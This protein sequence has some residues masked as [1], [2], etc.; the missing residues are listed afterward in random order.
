MRIDAGFRLALYVMLVLACLCLSYAEQDFMP[1]IWFIG[2]PAVGLLAVAYWIEGRWYLSGWAANVL[3]F[4]IAIASSSRLSDPSSC[5]TTGCSRGS[6][7]CKLSWPL[8]SGPARSW[9][10]Y[11]APT[12]WAPC[13][14]F[15]YSNCVAWSC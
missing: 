2:I 11:W 5:A 10:C 3:G 4:V 13:G 6:A 9:A 7:S 1:F 15:Y 8:P 12:C 14:A